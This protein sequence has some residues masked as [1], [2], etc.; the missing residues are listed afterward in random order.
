MSMVL[1]LTLSKLLAIHED[2]ATYD[3]EGWLGSVSNRAQHSDDGNEDSEGHPAVD[4]SILTSQN[5]LSDEGT[6]SSVPFRFIFADTR[7][8]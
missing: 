8:S 2:A 3:T 5:T 4:Q 1:Q 6:L 7:S